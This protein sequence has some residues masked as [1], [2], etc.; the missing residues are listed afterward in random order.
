VK[1]VILKHEL[2]DR[3][4][5]SDSKLSPT[6]MIGQSVMLTITWDLAIRLAAYTRPTNSAIIPLSTKIQSLRTDNSPG[7]SQPMPACSEPTLHYQYPT[8]S[9]RPLF[10]NYSDYFSTIFATCSMVPGSRDAQIHLLGDNHSL[11][12]LSQEITSDAVRMQLRSCRAGVQKYLVTCAIFFKGPK[13]LHS[14]L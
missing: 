13:T 1:D 8:Y 14:K 10:H 7:A 6:L 11:Q 9:C 2:N 5:S 4:S 12:V 3:T